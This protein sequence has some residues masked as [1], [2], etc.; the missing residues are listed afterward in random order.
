MDITGFTR[1][2]GFY[3][4]PA[5]HSISPKMHNTAFQELGIDAVYLAFE[6]DE[7]NLATSIQAIR[8]LNM[9]GVN[10]SMPHKTAAVA[11]MDELSPTAELTG[12]IN[13]V[14]NLDGRLIGH[15]TDGTGFMASLQELSIN[16][17]GQEITILGGGGAAVAIIAQAALDGVKTINVGLRN[18]SSKEM[19][20]NKLGQIAQQTKC[21]INVFDM[22]KQEALSQVLKQS[23]L[24]INATNMGMHPQVKESPIKD[25]NLL[26]ADLAVYDI[27][28]NPRET[29]L[30]KQAKAVGAKTCNGLPMLV[31]QGAEAFKL[32]TGQTMPVEKIKKIVE[33]S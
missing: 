31:H 4:K 29:L 1:L 27:I 9:L 25:P 19:L 23:V 30:L 14:V 11:F 26:R 16:P 13:T 8:S 20:R 2:A 33:N 6:V 24:L 22:E 15:T 18:L 32:W 12:A 7:K 10:L 3:A 17:I 21:E 5:K 28:Y